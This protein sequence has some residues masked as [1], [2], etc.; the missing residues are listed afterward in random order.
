MLREL[1]RG[2]RELA[3]PSICASCTI[4]LTGKQDD[5][6]SAC[7]VALAHD[8][9]TTCPRCCSS[10]GQFADGAE[11]CTDC[12]HERYYFERAFRLGRYD[13]HLR[14]LILRMKQPRG[15]VL[16]EIMG[17][18]WAAHAEARFRDVKADL[19]IPAPLHWRRRLFHRGFNQSEALSE[20][21]AG[22]IG[23]PHRTRWLRR[24]RAARSQVSLDGAERRL[25]LVGAY[26]ASRSADLKGKT[27]LL[28]DDVLT[29]GATVSEAS[30]ALMEA[31]AA[32]VVVA[33]LAHR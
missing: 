5:F 26:R 2:F 10:V 20:A 32:R 14:D 31:G 7:A 30:R 6:C 22:R 21:I 11:G 19:V 18:F 25:N 1:T 29:T 4:A 28:I 3:F 23:L 17:R 9:D 16:A 15:D 33:V 27:V 12:R 24:V 8:P 13:G